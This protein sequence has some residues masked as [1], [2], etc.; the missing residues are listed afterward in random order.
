MERKAANASQ[1]KDVNQN[2][3]SFVKEG[4]GGGAEV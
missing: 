2:D 1:E 3:F 4:V